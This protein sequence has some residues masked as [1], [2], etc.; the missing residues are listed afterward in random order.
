MK[1]TPTP[2]QTVGPFFSIGMARDDWSNLVNDKTAGQRIVI[3][4][5]VL[6]GDG[7]PV[8]DAVI[9]IWQANAAG[10]YKHPED[11]QEKVLDPAFLGFGRCA[12][13]KAGRFRFR[14]IKPGSVYGRG[15]R[16][17]APHINVSVFAR[18]I[19]RRLAT[20]IYFH[21]EPLNASD[22]VLNA[23]ADAGRRATLIACAQGGGGEPVY[24]FDV[25][26]QGARETVFLDI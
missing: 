6:D 3:E 17:Q 8:P 11:T 9:E 22:P 13:D 20:R 2:S 15:A 24:Q 1:L 26:L 21:D 4:G 18:G 7:A 5:R 14:T 16:A 25:V 19:L 12:S 23:I 10:R